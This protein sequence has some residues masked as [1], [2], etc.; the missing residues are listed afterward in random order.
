[1]K[2]THGNRKSDCSFFE[3][4]SLEFFYWIGFIMADGHISNCRLSITLSNKDEN[5]L[6]KLA[7]KLKVKVRK[8][9]ANDQRRIS[10]MNKDVICDIVDRF[11]ISNNKTNTP[12]DISKITGD[13]LKSLSIGFIDGDG[14]IRN[15]WNRK[16]FAIR[17]KCH[18]SWLENL[19]IMFPDEN[20]FVNNQGY[21]NVNI[22]NTT[23]CKE[24]K[25]FAIEN[26]LPIME[27]KW[28][29][30]NLNFISKGEL[31]KNR[32][33]TVSKMLLEGKNRKEI[34]LETGLSDSGLSLLISK[35][36]LI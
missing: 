27:R 19:K 16:D 23:T 28:D 12:C 25:T 8:I 32:I 10:L 35:N 17:V 9:K 7:D 6:K 15:L 5:H 33:V 1:M 18:K 4:D 14:N 26:D 3:K 20:C 2:N 34:K 11:N 29:I 13:N 31:S 24:L 36:K 30:I 21:A 22:S